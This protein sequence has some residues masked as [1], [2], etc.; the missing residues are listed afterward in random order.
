MSTRT[1][2]HNTQN[3]Q[4]EAA[5]ESHTRLRS[6]LM[7]GLWDYVQSSDFNDLTAIHKAQQIARIDRRVDILRGA[8]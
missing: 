4:P 6:T 3:C 8:K 2:L 5:S 1:R 7:D